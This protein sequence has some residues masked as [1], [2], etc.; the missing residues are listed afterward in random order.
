MPSSRSRLRTVGLGVALSAVV[1]LLVVGRYGL[2]LFIALLSL[3]V[4]VAPRVIAIDD[5]NRAAGQSAED[6][7]AVAPDAGGMLGG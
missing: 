6:G 1:G 3:V 7:P 5:A 4:W 2:A